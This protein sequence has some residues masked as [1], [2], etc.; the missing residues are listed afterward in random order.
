MRNLFSVKVKMGVASL[1]MLAAAATGCAGK[2]PP[3]TMGAVSGTIAC[4]T[5]IELS[6]NAVAYVRL[7]DATG[8]GLGGKTIVQQEIK[9]FAT[10][11]TTPITFGLPYKDKDINASR[12]YVVEVRIVDKGKLVLMNPVKYTVLTKG[13]PNTL[14]VTLALASEY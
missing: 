3:E 8:G 7:A 2:K 14:E 10:A 9:E 4:R 12:E 1:A 11:A 5:D 13:N 6:P